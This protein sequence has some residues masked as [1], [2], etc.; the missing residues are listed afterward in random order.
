MNDMANKPTEPKPRGR[1]P[2]AILKLNATPEQITRAI[3]SAVKKPSPEL[4]N[5]KVPPRAKK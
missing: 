1:P 2:K 4:R 5:T 3:F